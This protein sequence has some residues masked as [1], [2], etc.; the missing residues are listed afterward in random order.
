MKLW[1]ICLAKSIAHFGETRNV[2]RIFLVSLLKGVPLRRAR[3]ICQKSMEID[4]GKTGYINET[5][6]TRIVCG[7]L[8]GEPLEKWPYG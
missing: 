3:R 5:G 1:Q 6:Q 4:L 8:V 7:I 2:C